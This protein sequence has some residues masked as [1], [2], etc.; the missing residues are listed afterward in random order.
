MNYEACDGARLISLLN[1]LGISE[2]RVRFLSPRKRTIDSWCLVLN[3]NYMDLANYFS[4][5]MGCWKLHSENKQ[6]NSCLV[7]SEEVARNRLLL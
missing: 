6:Y 5:R 1:I 2:I 3:T 7:T 4:K